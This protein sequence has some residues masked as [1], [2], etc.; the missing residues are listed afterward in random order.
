MTCLIDAIE[1]R[2]VATLDI[3]GAFM[4]S[5]MEGLVIM[6]LEGVMAGVILKIDPAKYKKFTV[7]ERG[8]AVVYVKLT[9]A[10][11][12]TLQAALLFWQNLSSQLIE[13]RFELNPYDF[14]VVNKTIDGGQCTIVWHV[15]DLKISHVS[16]KAVDTVISLLDAK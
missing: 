11:Y 16:T 12:G 10:L 8:K 9:K 15:D 7:H 3:P 14:C 6:K 2:D 1:R 13:W 4:Q 5:E